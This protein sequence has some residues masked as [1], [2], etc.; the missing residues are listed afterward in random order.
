[1]TPS[2]F[3][4]KKKH[5]IRL[6]IEFYCFKQ[7]LLNDELIIVSEG[8]ENRPHCL[9]ACLLN[10]EGMQEEKA[11]QGQAIAAQTL[12]AECSL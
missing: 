11:L 8:A 4:M 7:A 9:C 6:P 1:M 12:Q 10:E 3:T 2:I 5:L